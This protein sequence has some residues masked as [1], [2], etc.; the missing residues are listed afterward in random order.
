MGNKAQLGNSWPSPP[1]PKCGC[2]GGNATGTVAE[3][4]DRSGTFC[5]LPSRIPEGCLQSNLMVVDP[6]HCWQRRARTEMW[7]G[8]TAQRNWPWP[9]LLIILGGR[10]Q[11]GHEAAWKIK[12]LQGVLTSG[13]HHGTA[14]DPHKYP[15]REKVPVRGEETETQRG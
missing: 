11:K 12:S 7:P 4:K 2:L 6:S 10:R 9:F 13:G 8:L 14:F 15:M 5:S 3:A 1:T